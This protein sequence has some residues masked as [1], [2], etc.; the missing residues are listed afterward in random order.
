MYFIFFQG[1]VLEF[2]ESMVQ[3]SYSSPI[4]TSLILSI[5]INEVLLLKNDAN[6][7]KS[8]SKHDAYINYFKNL[9]KFKLIK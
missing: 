2:E 4:L 5:P 8:L 9:K 1:C 6:L 7:T 3:L